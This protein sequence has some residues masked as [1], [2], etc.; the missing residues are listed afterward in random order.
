MFE[1]L[2]VYVSFF[3]YLGFD[4]GHQGR[5][6]RGSVFLS[7]LFVVGIFLMMDG[8]YVFSCLD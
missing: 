4:R 3:R 1:G 6:F 8:L 2:G 5:Q 7:F